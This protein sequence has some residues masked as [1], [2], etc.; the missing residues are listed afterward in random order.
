MTIY[1]VFWM[2]AL[3]LAPFIKSNRMQIAFCAFVF[4]FVGLRYETGFDWPTYKRAFDI[5]SIDFSINSILAYSDTF[6]VE[7]GWLVVT[8]LIGQ[9]FPEYEFLQAIVTLA[10]L[11]STFKLCRGLGVQNVAMAIA[12][13][14]SFLLL[15]LLFSTTRQCFAVSIFN[16][17]VVAAAKRRWT[18]MVALSAFAV[19][20]HTST[21]LYIVAM[22]YAAARPSKLPSTVMVAMMSALSVGFVLLIPLVAESLPDIIASRIIWYNLDQSFDNIGLWQI[23]FLILG[24]FILL[25][26]LFIGPSDDN[27]D[28]VSTF[29]RRMIIALAVTCMGTYSLDVIRDRISYEMFLMFSVYLARSDLLLR[30]PARLGAFCLGLF[31]S[32]LNIFSP[33]NRIVFMPYQNAVMVLLT[34]EAGD[35][36]ARQELFRREFDRRS[37][38]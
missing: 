38:S 7:I 5:L 21:I 31:F 10:F 34:G 14:S 13:A 15:T 30:V 4:V 6:K 2:L 28:H 11:G 35:G 20:I 3:G 36:P 33:D 1:L 23:Y 24:A 19:S 8:G 9:V 27:S 22:I 17:A 25:H 29:H 18:L 37:D 12:I 32:V 16:L 26:S